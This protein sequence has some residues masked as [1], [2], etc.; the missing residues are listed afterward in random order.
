MV[1]HH[2]FACASRGL[3]DTGLSIHKLLLAELVDA[4]ILLS[5]H[6]SVPG[7]FALLGRPVD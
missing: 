7:S 5:R 1:G 4:L 3:L 2:E 6:R